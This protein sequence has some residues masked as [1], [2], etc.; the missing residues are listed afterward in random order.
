M[1]DERLRFST[2][3]LARL[4]E[5]LNPHPDLGLLELAKN[6]FDADATE[7]T[8]ELVDTGRPGGTIRISDNGLGMDRESLRDGFLLLGTSLKERSKPTALGRV[9]VGNK[10]LGRLAALRLGDRAIVTTRP[11]NGVNTE[12]TLELDWE[13]Y[14]HAKTVDEVS[15]PIKRRPRPDGAENGTRIELRNLCTQLSRHCAVGLPSAAPGH[16]MAI[17]AA[18]RSKHKC[19]AGTI[20]IALGAGGSVSV[21]PSEAEH[22]EFIR[23][24]ADSALCSFEQEP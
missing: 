24:S 23:S 19:C 10:G 14:R 7:F 16:L 4:G 5:E 15:V 13:A 21:A 8:V 18:G 2:E 20:V 3:I 22:R 11:A 17:R 9:Q 12:L 1:A 6:A